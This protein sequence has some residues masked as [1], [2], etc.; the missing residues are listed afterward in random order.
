MTHTKE[1][2]PGSRPGLAR[3]AGLS[4]SVGGA[5]R[6]AVS[7]KAPVEADEHLVEGA[8]V[9]FD[10]AS[11]RTVDEGERLIIPAED[12][13]PFG[14]D[15]PAGSEHPFAADASVEIVEVAAAA[16]GKYA[17]SRVDNRQVAVSYK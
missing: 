8:T 4:R 6:T 1:K 11:S 2:A 5:H 16:C 3:V 9:G 10:K 15:R 17:A 14:K 7:T 13:V 12:V